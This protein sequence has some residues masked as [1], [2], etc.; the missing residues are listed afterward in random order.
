MH[1]AL[2]D[3]IYCPVRHCPVHQCLF[4]HFPPPFNLQISFFTVQTL[5]I[6]VKQATF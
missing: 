4:L 6:I 5:E 1:G 2:D 3:I